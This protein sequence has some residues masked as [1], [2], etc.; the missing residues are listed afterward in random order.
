M[1]QKQLS[2]NAYWATQI[3]VS[4]LFT[5][6]GFALAGFFLSGAGGPE[7]GRSVIYLFIGF[8]FLATLIW[9]IRQFTKSTKK[10]RAIYAWAIMQHED[11]LRRDGFAPANDARTM[12]IAARARDGKLTSEEL[13]ELQALRPDRPYPGD[14]AP[15]NALS[16]P[17]A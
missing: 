4:A 12:A 15:L 1:A 8:V 7:K 17:R 13:G 3:G 6:G 14:T 16:H 11:G 2:G 10:Q 9:L 5:V